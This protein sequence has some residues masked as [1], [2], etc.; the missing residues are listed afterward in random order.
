MQCST[1][2]AFLLNFAEVLE[3]HLVSGILDAFHY[4]LRCVYHT[5]RGLFTHEWNQVLGTVPTNATLFL[6]GDLYRMISAYA[7]G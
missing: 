3:D 6:I 2:C 1:F 7:M 5:S 4:A